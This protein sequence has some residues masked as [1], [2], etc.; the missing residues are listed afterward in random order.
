MM[1][2]DVSQKKFKF[3]VWRCKP[4]Y[5]YLTVVNGCVLVVQKPGVCASFRR[6]DRSSVYL[7]AYSNNVYKTPVR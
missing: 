5:S 3:A 2:S 1:S 7:T 6:Y 4:Q